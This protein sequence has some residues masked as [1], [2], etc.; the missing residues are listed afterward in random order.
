MARKD[1]VI[2]RS[3]EGGD[4]S[5]QPPATHEPTKAIPRALHN[6]MPHNAP[7]LK[8]WPTVGPTMS[9]SSTPSVRRSTRQTRAPAM[10]N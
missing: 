1:E 2:C 6:L 4:Q 8:G 10:M 9:P 3:P 7:G 5:P